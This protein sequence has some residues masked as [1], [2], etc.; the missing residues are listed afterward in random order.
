M[1]HTTRRDFLLKSGLGLGAAAVSGFVPGI[2]FINAASAA[3]LA[4]PLAP[5]APHFPSKVKSVIWLHQ[6]GAPSTLDL[7]DYKPELVRLAGQEVPASFLKGIKTSTQG[8]VGKL[9]VSPN[10]SWK[11]Y[12]ESG[13]WFSN[14]LPNLATQADKLAFIKSSVTVGA[15]HDISI[16][17]LNTGDLNPGRPSLGAWVTY[18]LGSNNPDLPAYVVLYNGDSEPSGGSVNWSSGFLPAVYQGTAFR[19]GDSP[20]LYLERPELRSASQ[21]RGSLDL[22]KRL[23]NLGA[24]RYPGDTELRARL[25]SYEL[26]DRMQAAAPEAVSL[27]KETEATKKLYGLDDKTSESYGTALLRARR[28]V[29]RGV[30]FIQVVSGWPDSATDGDRRSWDAHNDIDGNHGLMAKM[31]DKPI[32]G[33]LADLQSR[34]LLES[35]LVVWTSEFGRTSWGESGTGRDHNPWGY[36]TWLAGAGVKA[37]FTY[38]ATDEIGLQAADKENSVDT[39]DLHATVLHLLGLD[40]LKTTFLNNGRS[41]RPTVVYGRVVHELLA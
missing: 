7:Y 24:E 37:G 3:D 11:Q 9:F 39:Y 6:N 8:G 41:E 5:R 25:Q 14:L 30:R 22:L 2:G 16:L 17:K 38:G 32:A 10:R 4:N 26:A 36:T 1:S 20:I 33:L 19:P 31:V 21:Q 13:A 18:A 29:E 28:L 27:A 23:N 40:H 34:G 15:T 12:G 35:T